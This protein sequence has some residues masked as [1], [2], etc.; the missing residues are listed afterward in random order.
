[1]VAKWKAD[2][3]MITVSVKNRR[4]KNFHHRD[5]EA[6]RKTSLPF[7]GRV[8]VGMGFL[9]VSVVNRF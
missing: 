5:T 2:V 1:M 8:R 9:C 4:A 7:K 6:Q 3:D